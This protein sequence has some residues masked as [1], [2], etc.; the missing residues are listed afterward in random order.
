MIVI[1]P[2]DPAWP[3][4]FDDEAAL[5]RRLLGPLALRVDHVGSTSVRG[6]AAK[7]VIDIQISVASL[8]TLD[9]YAAP[10]AE[11][12]YTRLTD[13][14]PEFERSYPFFRKPADWPRTHHVHLCVAGS[15][16]ERRHLAFRDYLRDHDDVASQYLELKRAL[17]ALHI[18]ATHDA[19]ERYAL[20]KGPFV[21]S[22]LER[23]YAAGYPRTG[24]RN[25]SRRS[26]E[27]R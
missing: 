5:L 6:L 7:P 23:A 15:E 22:V 18:G 2:Y 11:A 13:P 14:D 4:R 3:A 25:A 21:E 16:M 10:L 27:E 8:A 20:A 9:P 26:L 24:P 17:A 19:R 1:V 12:G